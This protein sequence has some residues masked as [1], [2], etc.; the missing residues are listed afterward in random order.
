MAEETPAPVMV[1]IPITTKP[2]MVTVAAK[3]IVVTVAPKLVITKI[4]A[5]ALAYI[6]VSVVPSAVAFLRKN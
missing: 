5:P 4:T 1:I 3:L 6:V 2:I